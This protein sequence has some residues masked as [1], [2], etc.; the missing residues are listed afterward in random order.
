[1]KDKDYKRLQNCSSLEAT[2]KT[3]QLHAAHNPGLNPEPEKKIILL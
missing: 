3:K 2:K 1:M